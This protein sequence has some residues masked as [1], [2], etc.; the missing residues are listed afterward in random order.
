MAELVLGKEP[1][2]LRDDW[3]EVDGDRFQL[4][5]DIP[6]CVVETWVNAAAT[7]SSRMALIRGCLR[8]TDQGRF[9]DAV[10][11]ARLVRDRTEEM[12]SFVLGVY[13]DRPTQQ[14]AGSPTTPDGSATGSTVGSRSRGK[15]RRGSTS[16]A[17]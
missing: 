5:A 2:L 17:A 1:E 3:I 8:D 4:L 13:S 14:P 10:A 16:D 15:T 7:V 11:R 12:L 6:I 9:D